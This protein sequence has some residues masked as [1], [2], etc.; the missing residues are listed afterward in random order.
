MP[1][2]NTASCPPRTKFDDRRSVLP[3]SAFGRPGFQPTGSCACHAPIWTGSEPPVLPSRPLWCIPAHRSGA[4]VSHASDP[5]ASPPASTIPPDPGSRDRAGE[6]FQR[7]QA[8]RAPAHKIGVPDK[9]R[10]GGVSR[11]FFGAQF[12]RI[13]SSGGRTLSRIS[14]ASGSPGRNSA[15]SARL[16]S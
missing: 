16:W 15:G 11:F 4:D 8:H 12:E 14:P 2:K 7:F 13:D 9:R 3:A 10:L 1:L 6:R 5:P